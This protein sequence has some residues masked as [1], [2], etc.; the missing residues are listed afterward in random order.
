MARKSYQTCHHAG[1]IASRSEFT[2]R[3]NDE[4][5]RR[6][7]AP[8]KFERLVRQKRFIGAVD[9]LNGSL[10]NIFS[11]EL[12]DVPAVASVRDE[13]LVEKGRILDVLVEEI[14]D[15]LFLRAA[16]AQ[17]NSTEKARGSLQ[18]RRRRERGGAVGAPTDEVSR[19]QGTGAVSSAGMSSDVAS[20]SSAGAGGVDAAGMAW[21]GIQVDVTD[22]GDH[23]EQALDEPS[24]EFSVYLRL[25]VE[26]VRR[27]RCL[28]DIE[29]FLLERLPSEVL[30]LSATH[31]R[32]CVGRHEEDGFKSRGGGVHVV[33]R[34]K[35]D[36]ASA[37][38]LAQY[39]S[40]V[41][42]SFTCVLAN[43]VRLVRLLHAARLRDLRDSDPGTPVFEADVSYKES[44]V[45][46]LWQH[47]Q[48]HLTDVL[49][50][51]V[52]DDADRSDGAID[53]SKGDVGRAQI[54]RPTSTPSG[55]EP[56]NLSS[57]VSYF[58]PL[59]RPEVSSPGLTSTAME[60]D[61][62][63]AAHYCTSNLLALPSPLILINI[64]RP[65]LKFVEVEQVSLSASRCRLVV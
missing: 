33:R 8:V 5:L 48:T 34:S 6:Q 3:L 22:V 62:A 11:P 17:F 9:L 50:R 43:L 46:G 51:H 53:A 7:D 27:L 37:Q 41:F 19:A 21:A 14:A 4:F 16:T 15:V 35:N 61:Q 20:E 57:S 29:R 54:A 1:S 36:A 13:M 56:F 23:E 52:A 18:A 65:S 40:L 45:T 2:H 26:A 44:L 30:T 28:D 10:L 31:M 58:R 32:T 24:R 59:R 63:S 64:F 39:L 47:M 60:L 25:L 42:D 38:N 49:G 55:T 12:V